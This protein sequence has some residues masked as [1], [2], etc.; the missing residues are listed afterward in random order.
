ML[1]LWQTQLFLYIQ[2]LIA[3]IT[4]CSLDII[5]IVMATVKIF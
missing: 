2:F 4:L 5:T 3:E 1:P